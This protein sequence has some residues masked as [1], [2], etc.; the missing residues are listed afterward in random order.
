MTALPLAE[1]RFLSNN[2]SR[3]KPPTSV[4]EG[5]RFGVVGR[6]SINLNIHC[7]ICF[8]F[9]LFPWIVS[10]PVL[11]ATFCSYFL[12]IHS[13]PPKTSVAEGAATIGAQWWAPI[14]GSPVHESHFHGSFITRQVDVFQSTLDPLVGLISPLSLKMCAQVLCRV[15]QKRFKMLFLMVWEEVGEKKTTK[16]LKL[17][18]KV[19]NL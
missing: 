15:L 6:N 2:F 10:D 18:C 19:T 4:V 13:I 3:S 12:H 1:K 7:F 5:W 9:P 16:K 8:T 17:Y 11:L 14:A